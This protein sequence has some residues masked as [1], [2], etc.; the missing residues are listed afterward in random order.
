MK[1]KR[2]TYRFLWGNQKERYHY[3]ELDISWKIILQEVLGRTSRLLPFDT[4]R[5]EQKTK[6]LR[7]YTDTQ[8][9]G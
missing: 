1:E 4:T 6:K 5:T 9:V 3:E 2:C 8:T 7:G